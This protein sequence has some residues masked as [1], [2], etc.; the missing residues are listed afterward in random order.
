MKAKN[1]TAQK[2]KKP[3]KAQIKAVIKFLKERN[4]LKNSAP[5]AYL[6]NSPHRGTTLVASH[7]P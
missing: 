6:S 4:H 3:T 7:L 2:A 1:N 5:L